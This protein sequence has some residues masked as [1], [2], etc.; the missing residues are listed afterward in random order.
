MKERFAALPTLVL[1]LLGVLQA[2][3]GIGGD[4][5]S[6]TGSSAA[7]KLA[8]AE[9]VVVYGLTTTAGPR[10]SQSFSTSWSAE[11]LDVSTP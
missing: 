1:V 9:R 5:A 3:H 10:L 2:T 7:N 4:E 8:Q 6:E 11:S